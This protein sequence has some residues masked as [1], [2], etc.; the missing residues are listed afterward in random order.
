MVRWSAACCTGLKHTVLHTTGVLCRVPYLPMGSCAAVSGARTLGMGT[1]KLPAASR[2][3]RVWSPLQAGTHSTGQVEQVAKAY[4]A[5]AHALK[6]QLSSVL[7][8][9]DGQGKRS[10]CFL[11]YH[12]P[13]N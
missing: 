6:P 3:Q 4:R 2:Y 5:C 9:L 8:H 10:R 1:K 11:H 13:C 7:L 12:I